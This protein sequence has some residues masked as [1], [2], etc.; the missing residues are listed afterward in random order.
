[1]RFL[2]MHS[3]LCIHTFIL[4]VN[5]GRHITRPTG[6][7]FLVTCWLI[8][9]LADATVLRAQATRPRAAAQCQA[10]TDHHQTESGHETQF[11]SKS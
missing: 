7:F 8:C 3:A 5:N 1:M 4:R 9:V 10:Q 6:K 2:G 11:K